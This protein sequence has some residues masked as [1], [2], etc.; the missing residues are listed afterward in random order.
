MNGWMK[1]WIN[2]V[3]EYMDET[4]TCLNIICCLM[5]HKPHNYNPT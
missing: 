2:E 3:D 5:C 4:N 1:E